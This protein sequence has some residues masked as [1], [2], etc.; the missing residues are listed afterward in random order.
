MNKIE[1]LSTAISIIERCA[2]TDE[3]EVNETLKKLQQMLH[4][5]EYNLKRRKI[6]YGNKCKVDP[7]NR[8]PDSCY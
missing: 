5:E 8:R 2:N 1:A 6:V 3:V 4:R 7:N